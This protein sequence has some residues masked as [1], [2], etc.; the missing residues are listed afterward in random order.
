[1]ELRAMKQ[2]KIPLTSPGTTI[3]ERRRLIEGPRLLSKLPTAAQLIL[4][5]APLGQDLRDLNKEG[6]QFSYRLGDR[7]DKETTDV[8]RTLPRK[9]VQ[10]SAV[11]PE[12][13]SVA[14]RAA[15]GKNQRIEAIQPSSRGL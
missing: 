8:E 6:F 10:I 9:V 5:S 11:R 2:A 15:A 14:K 13:V 4:T 12:T 1:M 7:D 3:S